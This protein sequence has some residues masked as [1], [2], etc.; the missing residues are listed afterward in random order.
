MNLEAAQIFLLIGALVGALIIFVDANSAPLKVSIG[1][2]LV[3]IP[4]QPIETPRLG[5]AN[6]IMT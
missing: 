3:F 6:I 2:L 1:I 5:S 4:F